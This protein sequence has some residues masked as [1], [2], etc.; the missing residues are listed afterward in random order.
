MFVIWKALSCRKR[1]Q[2]LFSAGKYIPLQ[3]TGQD[4]I[5]VA[6]ARNYGDRWALIVV[7]LRVKERHNDPSDIYT[8]DEIVLPEN[9]PGLWRNV[10]TG[11]IVRAEKRIPLSACLTRFSVALFING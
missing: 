1:D 10:F 11:E 2:L 9:A 4:I 5:T 7:P 3:V 8:D 6:F